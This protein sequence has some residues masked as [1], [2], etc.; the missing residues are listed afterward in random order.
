MRIGI[1]K[2]IKPQEFRVSAT[3]GAVQALVGAGHQVLVERGA[4]AGSSFSDD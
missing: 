1:T 2:E 4:G 3:P